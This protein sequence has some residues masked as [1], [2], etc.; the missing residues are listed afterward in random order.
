MPV[1][2]TYS[3]SPFKNGLR[4]EELLHLLRR[5]LFGVG[6][7]E[8]KFFTGKTLQNCLDI[9]LTQSPTPQPLVLWDSDMVDPL[10][11]EGK[12]WV[13]APYENVLLD[14]IRGEQLKSW[15]MGHIINRDFSLTAKMSLFLHNHF[16]IEM[17]V[18]KDARYSYRY[19][20]LLKMNALGNFKNLIKEGTVTPGMLVYLN[21]NS[22]NK[23]AP[24]ENYS[25]ELM[26]LFTI[27]KGAKENYTEDDVKSA[28]R[29]LTG[30]KDNKETIK[31]EFLPSL[32]DTNDKQFSSFFNNRV[33]KGKGGINGALEKDELIDMIFSKEETARFFCRNIYRW[34]V[35]GHID[36]SIETYII[37][38]LSEIFIK[39]G[40]EIIPVL[41]TLLGSEH[42]F[43]Q[44]FRGCIV[45]S[46]VD[47]FLG[48]IQQ[49]D[50]ITTSHLDTNHNSWFQFY[51][52]TEDLTLNLGDPPSVAGWPAYYQPPKFHQWWVNSASLGMRKKI[53]DYL[54]TPEGVVF[55]G[56]N[57]MFDFMHF[58]SQFDCAGNA[59]QFFEECCDLFFALPVSSTARQKLKETL[60]S[61]E[62]AAKNWAEEWD[63]YNNN[64]EDKT[65]KKILESKV[66]AFF[67][68]V[69]CMPEFQMC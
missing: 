65:A 55:N 3:L 68:K 66:R 39:N 44:A 1:V 28:A 43:D 45:K 59:D 58:L 20:M 47:Y 27:G 16:V 2:P 23:E 30:W 53:L 64:K 12:V 4:K 13:N 48:A 42:F 21:G 9:I 67:M 49:M 46:P 33:I 14:F 41:R 35:S 18:V 60:I 62:G 24:N 10:V 31:S 32:H 50:T 51:I 61:H 36:E 29:V 69:I 17:D 19:Y 34:F 25:R 37:K 5:C 15:W 52:Y 40:F 8:L 63:K 54:C 56:P 11:P 57:I 38:P 7:K 6:Q 26:E 22:N